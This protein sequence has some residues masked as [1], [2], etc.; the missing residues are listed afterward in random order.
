VTGDWNVIQNKSLREL[1]EKG[2]TYREEQNI[3]WKAIQNEISK[4]LTQC[5][6]DWAK[7]EKRDPVHL[8]EWKN[9]TMLKAMTRI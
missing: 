4:G 9:K 5:N 7:K 6:L 3:N 2:P 8:D 1:L